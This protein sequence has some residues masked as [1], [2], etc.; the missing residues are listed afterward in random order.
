M[1]NR[2]SE[3][4]YVSDHVKRKSK[5][6]SFINVV[7]YDFHIYIDVNESDRYIVIF[8]NININENAKRF[9][10]LNEARESCCDERC[11]VVGRT[12]GSLMIGGAMFSGTERQL[13]C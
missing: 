12:C 10:S 11:I 8:I 5:Y 9:I 3:R 13:L 1:W 7:F 2:Y 4:S 6:I